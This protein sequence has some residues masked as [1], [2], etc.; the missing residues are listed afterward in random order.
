VRGLVG[1]ET[2]SLEKGDRYQQ[3]QK[4]VDIDRAM[5][6]YVHKKVDE[7][8]LQFS[9]SGR[10]S[11]V[12]NVESAPCIMGQLLDSLV[13]LSTPTLGRAGAGFGMVSSLCGRVFSRSGGGLLSGLGS[14]GH[15]V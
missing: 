15:G 4:K 5:G 8:V 1:I 7:E 14:S 3:Q 10:I 12:P 11:E 13:D 6:Q 2:A 9:L